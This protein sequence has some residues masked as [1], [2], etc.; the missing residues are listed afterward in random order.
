MIS[1]FCHSLIERI[2]LHE[3]GLW[4]THRNFPHRMGLFIVAPIS[5][6]REAGES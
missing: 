1:T 5:G 6:V 3:R 2:S 4:I